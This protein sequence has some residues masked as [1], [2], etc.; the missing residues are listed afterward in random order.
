[1][2]Q[3]HLGSG[4]GDV[5]S[6]TSAT[7]KAATSTHHTSAHSAAAHTA[8]HH[9]STHSATTHPTT[10]STMLSH[11]GTSHASSVMMVI[12]D[13]RS[14]VT[15]THAAAVGLIASR[16]AEAHVAGCCG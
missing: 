10:H 14:A 4:F 16:A 6:L 5:G 11:A 8:A 7:S 12:H 13:N 1:M 15:A 2:L 3:K 9:T